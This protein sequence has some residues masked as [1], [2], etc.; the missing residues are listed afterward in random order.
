MTILDVVIV[1]TVDVVDYANGI[2]L[3][4]GLT[5]LFDYSWTRS[6]A[7]L[8]SADPGAPGTVA[9]TVKI[10]N[11]GSNSTSGIAYS[12]NIFDTADSRVEVV[13]RPSL[14][15]LD[16]VGSTF[17]SGS[18][19]SV[20][21]SGQ[22]GSSLTDKSFGVSLSVTPTFIDDE[23]M[24]LSVKAG[25]S[26]VEPVSSSTFDQSI[27][28]STNTVTA[29]ALVRFGETVVLSGLREREVS[30]AAS[31]VPVLNQVPGIQYLFNRKVENDYAKHVIV[32]VT[33]RRPERF[34]DVVSDAEKHTAEMERVGR[35]G[36]L[37]T[38]AAS[39]IAQQE[40]IYESNLRAITAKMSLNKYYQEFK[41]G[42]LSPRRFYPQ[43][44]LNRIFTDIMRVLYY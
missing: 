13:A 6:S 31:G 44:T 3:L 20:A 38:E 1:R 30:S 25:R 26:F 27:S 9:R 32:L 17:F 10:N 36:A 28:A 22:W 2:N 19:V 11:S 41:T 4:A 33:P 34:Q 18:T 40:K 15:A 14:V 16:R 5:M 23:T 43:G 12:L 21:T 37:T 7:T 39:A 8:G 42:D 35:R 24:L 29:N